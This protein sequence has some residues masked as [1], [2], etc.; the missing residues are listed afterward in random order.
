MSRRST[1]SPSAAEIRDEALNELREVLLGV[2]SQI[3]VTIG[4]DSL[5]ETYLGMSLEE[6]SLGSVPRGYQEELVAIDLDRFW[7]AKQVRAASSFALQ[8]GAAEERMAFSEGDWNDLEIFL[9]GAPHVSFGGELTP[10]HNEDSTLRRTLEMAL[11]RMHL[12]HG[13]SLTVR[14]LSLLAGIGETAVRTSLSADGIKTEGKPA[15]VSADVAEPWLHRR[16][17]F[18]PTLTMEQASA[19][20]KEATN[21]ASSETSLAE[22]IENLCS[23]RDMKLGT[24]ARQAQ[25]DDQWLNT[26][27]AGERVAYDVEAL[28]RIAK[29]LG[30]DAPLFVGRAITAILQR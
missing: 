28:C 24:L 14:Q 16:R 7:I 3:V 20:T 21:N 4:D 10:L 23:G 19:E 8:L 22:E 2:A 15:Q 29:T 9:E 5:A 6:Y 26:L 18:V 27:M 17:G 12:M 30:I 25:I 13:F 1:Q 11:A